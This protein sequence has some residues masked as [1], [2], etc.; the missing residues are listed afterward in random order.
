MSSM[1]VVQRLCPELATIRTDRGVGG[2]TS[3]VGSQVLRAWESLR[4]NLDYLD[5]E[6]LP[7]SLR[8]LEPI[9]QGL[10]HTPLLGRHKYL[11]Y[12]KWF[13]KELAAYVASE[14]SAAR[15]LGEFLNSDS[16]IRLAEEHTTGRRNRLREL[17]LVLTLS[18]VQRM[19]RQPQLRP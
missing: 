2:Q 15:S 4:F 16:I 8:A 6:G 3:G 5:K 1:S 19:I 13:Q 9:L 10:R 17:N 11:P 7:G 14:A 18:A 12:R